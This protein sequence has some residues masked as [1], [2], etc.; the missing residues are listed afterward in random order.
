MAQ[1]SQYVPALR[2]DLA[3]SQLIRGQ[4]L[5]MTACN[6]CHGL[7]L[8]GGFGTPDLAIL[9]AYSDTEFRRLMKEGVAIGGRDSLRLMTMVARDRFAYFTEQEV[10]DLQA[11]LRTLVHEPVAKGVPWRPQP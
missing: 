9:T 11:Y 4:Y 10:V 5:A 7:D 3:D 1:W 8:R 2:T 6:E